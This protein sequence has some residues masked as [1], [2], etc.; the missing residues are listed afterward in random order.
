VQLGE[1]VIQLDNWK[2]E[3]FTWMMAQL[4]QELP[5]K[6]IDKATGSCPREQGVKF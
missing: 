5:T 6:G 4:H 1:K 2:E 3:R